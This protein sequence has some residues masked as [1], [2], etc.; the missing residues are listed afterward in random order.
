MIHQGT[1][2]E[3]LRAAGAGIPAFFTRT[4]VETVIHRGGAPIKYKKDGGGEVETAS[5][6]RE[7]GI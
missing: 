1:L 4:G 2:A 7:V 3:R 6:P 5:K